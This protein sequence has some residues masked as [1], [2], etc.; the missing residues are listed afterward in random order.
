MNRQEIF[1]STST[2]A[3]EDKQFLAEELGPVLYVSMA[4]EKGF[5]RTKYHKLF[6]QMLQMEMPHVNADKGPG[7][8]VLYATEAVGGINYHLV[9]QMEGRR[10]VYELREVVNAAGEYMSTG[11]HMIIDALKNYPDDLELDMDDHRIFQKLG[12]P[13]SY[14]TGN[15]NT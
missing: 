12:I 11:D 9:Y 6:N 10:K 2:K 14:L 5:T 13:S 1:T 4:E 15:S 3:L 8:L 7:H